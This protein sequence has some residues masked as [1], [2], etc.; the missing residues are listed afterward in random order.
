MDS[1][2]YNEV[3]TGDLP[4]NVERTRIERRDLTDE[5][6]NR[7]LIDQLNSGP[8]VVT[9]TGHG[10]TGIWANSNI[11]RSSDAESLTNERLSAYLLMT[12]LNGYTSSPHANS[13]AEVLMKSRNGAALVWASTGTTFP[14]R[15]FEMTQIMTNLIFDASNSG[16]RVGDTIIRAKR[17]T[18]DEDVRRTWLLIGDPTSF[19][20]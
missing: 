17:A 2:A 19:I 5:Q 13:L 12:C 4:A 11:F 15:Q 8:Q 6:M 7:S 10:S 18:Q 16:M 9:Y 1:K 20:K 3:L 14:N